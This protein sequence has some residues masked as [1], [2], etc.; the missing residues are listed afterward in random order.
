MGR[1]ATATTTTA[2]ALSPAAAE[3]DS[4]RTT[5]TQ[6]AAPAARYIARHPFAAGALTGGIE[7]LITFPF[8]F[9]K[10][11]RWGL[12]GGGV[13]VGWGGLWD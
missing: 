10:V 5:T 9:I 8:E 12:G 2:M 6:A 13:V 7:I 4:R 11:S 3:Q 1:P